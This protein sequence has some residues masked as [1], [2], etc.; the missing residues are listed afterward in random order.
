MWSERFRERLAEADKRFRTL[1]L[2]EITSLKVVAS[3]I[4]E[5]LND[6]DEEAKTIVDSYGQVM[7]AFGLWKE[8]VAR[9][10]ESF[11]A[12]AAEFERKAGQI[13]QPEIKSYYA[14]FA[15]TS[16]APSRHATSR[17]E[18]NFW[19]RNEK[20]NPSCSTSR[21]LANSSPI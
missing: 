17:K 10:P 16:R 7:S 2:N 15:A 19:S 21:H 4:A 13:E 14:D 9:A 5:I 12:V 1:D 8:A 6:L 3:D 11:R 20:S 18:R